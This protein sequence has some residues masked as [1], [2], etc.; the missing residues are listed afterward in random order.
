MTIS[1]TQQDIEIIETNHRA[2]ASNII[3]VSKELDSNGKMYLCEISPST[4]TTI[5]ELGKI[6]GRSKEYELKKHLA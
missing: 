1:L 3:I 4:A 5:F 6:V 2:K